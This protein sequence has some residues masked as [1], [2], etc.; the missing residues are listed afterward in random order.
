MG[1]R[2]CVVPIWRKKTEEGKGRAAGLLEVRWKVTVLGEAAWS[3]FSLRSRCRQAPVPLGSVWVQVLSAVIR[4]AG[5]MP[6]GPLQERRAVPL[7]LISAR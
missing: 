2:V 5:G 7:S 6:R 4:V 1:N 3:G